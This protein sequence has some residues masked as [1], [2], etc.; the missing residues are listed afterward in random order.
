MLRYSFSYFW[1]QDERNQV[2][3]SH[4]WLDQE[5]KDEKL[6]WNPQSYNGLKVLR[7]PCKL[8]WK[9]DIILYNRCVPA[10]IDLLTSKQL[11]HFDPGAYR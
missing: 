2:L 5:W 6:K 8:I 3:T 11:L 7:V 10:H 9:P 1:L 4:I